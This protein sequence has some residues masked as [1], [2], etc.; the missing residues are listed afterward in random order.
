V[1]NAGVEL[2]EAVGLS[3]KAVMEAGVGSHLHL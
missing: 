3:R 1:L 2:Q